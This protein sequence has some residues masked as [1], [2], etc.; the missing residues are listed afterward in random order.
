LHNNSVRFNKREVTIPWF[1]V[2][3]EEIDLKA[4]IEV[5]SRALQAQRA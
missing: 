2:G 5:I 3:Q 4:T 1:R